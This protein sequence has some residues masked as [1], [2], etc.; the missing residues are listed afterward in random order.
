MESVVV[1]SN[2]AFTTADTFP[3]V[4]TPPA[5]DIE[6]P[7]IVPATLSFTFKVPEKPVKAVS[8]VKEEFVP[9]I[10]MLDDWLA[11]LNFVK[12]LPENVDIKS[13]TDIN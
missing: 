12:T 7:V 1:G 9:K 2:V 8:K 13:K 4:R 5:I 3:V 10:L 6:L 11:Q